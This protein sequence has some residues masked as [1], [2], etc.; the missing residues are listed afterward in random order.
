M[1]YLY[2]DIV[3]EVRKIR[4][5]LFEEYGSIETNTLTTNSLALKKK[6]GCLP[7]RIL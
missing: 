4:E 2:T 1:K 3:G 6:V 7:H 5:D